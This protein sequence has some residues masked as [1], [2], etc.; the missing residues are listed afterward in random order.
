MTWARVPNSIVAF[1]TSEELEEEG[2]T[3]E[4]EEGATEE[5]EEGATEELEET[6]KELTGWVLTWLEAGALELEATGEE[7]AGWT[8]ELV[9]LETTGGTLEE[10]ALETGAGEEQ[11][12][13][14]NAADKG[15]ILVRFMDNLLT[16]PFWKQ[17]GGP[18][19]IN[20]LILRAPQHCHI[21]IVSEQARHKSGSRIRTRPAFVNSPPTICPIRN[22]HTWC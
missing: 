18:V 1:F 19:D 4:L 22:T 16:K 14:N 6:G 7:L 13:S 15:R 17:R 21:R 12:M 8:L 10:E 11:D 20:R 2:A 5:L 9:W 3:E